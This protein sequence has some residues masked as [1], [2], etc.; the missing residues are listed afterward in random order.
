MN[1][2]Q[3]ITIQ[4]PGKNEIF[5]LE[6]PVGRNVHEILPL[7]LKSF[8]F[9]PINPLDQQPFALW[10]ED[11][12]VLKSNQSFQQAG[13][14]NFQLLIL[15]SKP[16]LQG[17][18]QEPVITEAEGLRKSEDEQADLHAHE[19]KEPETLYAETVQPRAD[20][21]K[22]VQDLVAVPKSPGLIKTRKS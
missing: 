15:D 7:I 13:V 17:S 22:S 6:V 2:R 10:K 12:E 19:L 11:G 3:F 8:N 14:S 9:P 20:L 1:T 4:L 5:D 21:K 16:P 18:S